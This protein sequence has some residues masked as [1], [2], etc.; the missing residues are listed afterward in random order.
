MRHRIPSLASVLLLGAPRRE[1]VARMNK[2]HKRKR[3]G[4]LRK[5]FRPT[6]SDWSCT[7][8]WMA[9]ACC[10]IMCACTASPNRVP[11][12]RNT[13]KVQELRSTCMCPEDYF[14]GSW[15]MLSEGPVES[16]VTLFRAD[17][18]CGT[19]MKC[20]FPGCINK[21]SF[22]LELRHDK[23]ATFHLSLGEYGR[24]GIFDLWK[25]V[26]NKGMYVGAILLEDLVQPDQS[27]SIDHIAIVSPDQF[28]ARFSEG[29]RVRF[30][31]LSNW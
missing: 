23:S 21:P 26:P 30:V 31:R 19:E 15:G 13:T 16:P 7:N 12:G 29:D 10:C 5:V 8:R 20:P 27:E 9:L 22:H 17:A 2:F 18:D 14:V 1:M 28:V 24:I 6:Q 4:F 25:P 3:R 11:C